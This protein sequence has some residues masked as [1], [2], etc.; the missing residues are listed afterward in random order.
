M[1]DSSRLIHKLPRLYNS[2]HFTIISG[3]KIPI[4]PDCK[5]YPVLFIPNHTRLRRDSFRFIH[6]HSR[7]QDSSR[8]ILKVAKLKDS[9]RRYL[10]LSRLQ[11]SFLLHKFSRLQYS[12]CLVH[13]DDENRNISHL[14]LQLR[15]PFDRII[16]LFY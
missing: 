8:L 4:I 6:Y 2:T 14:L 12:F 13:R 10:K 3:C 15:T 7:L 5:M 16:R 1:Q 9:S 11:D